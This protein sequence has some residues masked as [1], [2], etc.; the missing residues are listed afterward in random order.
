MHVY[1]T[2]DTSFDVSRWNNDLQCDAIPLFRLCRFETWLIV[3]PMRLKSQLATGHPAALD[4]QR[5]AW[6]RVSR[7]P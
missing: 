7:R 1:G 2:G 4:V 6:T 3:M 5:R